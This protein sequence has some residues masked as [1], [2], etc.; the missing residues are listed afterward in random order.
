MRKASGGGE[1]ERE[2]EG[3][4]GRGGGMFRS[5]PPGTMYGGMGYGNGGPLH[6]RKDERKVA[7]TF[8]RGDGTE[9]GDDDNKMDP[10]WDCVWGLIWGMCGSDW[11]DAW[12]MNGVAL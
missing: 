9:V 5:C 10:G 4:V 11:R 1:G 12:L 2:G 8:G 6:K 3:G 7:V